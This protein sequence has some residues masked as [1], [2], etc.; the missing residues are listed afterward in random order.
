MDKA[1][2]ASLK[3]FGAALREHWF[4]AMSGGV[5]VPF[6]IAAAYLDNAAAKTLLALAAITCAWFAAYRVWKPEREKVIDL[7][8]RLLPKVILSFGSKPPW[9]IRLPRSNIPK[10]G[11]NTIV[12]AP[13]R[14]F[15]VKVE[16]AGLAA[17][18]HG[19]TVALIR[20][21]Y[22]Y[23][24]EFR[25]TA[26]AVPQ[27][28]RWAEAAETGFAE[29]EVRHLQPKF[30]DILSVDP[31]HNR[32]LIKW[33]T[34][35]IAYESLFDNVGTYRLTIAATSAEG[36]GSTV[37]LKLLW[38]GNWETAEVANVAG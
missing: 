1:R 6:A 26:F 33:P 29:V 34:S 28:L 35:W 3:S 24:G 31:I 19:V 32:I 22:F 30:V 23:E 37:Q 14:W 7:E 38:T 8:K 16:N 15:R 4:T 2:D 5:S 27:I 13:S 10:P 17:P 21:E 12:E 25:E 9:C 20:V 11:S 18:A 36:K